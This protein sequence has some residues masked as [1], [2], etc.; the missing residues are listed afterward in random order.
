MVEEKGGSNPVG[1]H[2]RAPSGVRPLGCGAFHGKS[3]NLR[4]GGRELH[5]GATEK[6]VETLHATSL[7]LLMEKGITSYDNNEFSTMHN[8]SAS[9][10]L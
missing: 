2:R 7:Q 4:Q 3:R 1:A 5:L 6:I 8:E 10:I 9:S